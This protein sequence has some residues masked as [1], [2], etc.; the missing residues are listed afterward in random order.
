MHLSEL[1]PS[2]CGKDTEVDVKSSPGLYKF[3]VHVFLFTYRCPEN[4]QKACIVALLTP[5]AHG[6]ALINTKQQIYIER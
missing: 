4:K 2:V 5:P 6:T 3:F 1:W